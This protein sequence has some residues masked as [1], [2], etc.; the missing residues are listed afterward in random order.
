M[1]PLR[2]LRE[3]DRP[4]PA[5]IEE[6]LA[7]DV[8][9][10]S[11]VWTKPVVGRQAVAVTIANSSKNRGDGAYVA[12]HRIDE[13]TTFLRWQGTIEGHKFESLEL[14]IDNKEG[15]LV[16]RTIAY[17]PFPSLKIFRDRMKSA[18]QDS[19]PADMWDW[20]DQS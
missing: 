1:H 11:P 18:M 16:E 15:L 13:R 17:R 14:L 12:E 8:V 5:E 2:K 7:E 4:T 6:I 3:S 10:N 9:F 20:P 19:V